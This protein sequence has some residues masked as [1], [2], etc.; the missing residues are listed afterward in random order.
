MA[1]PKR[2]IEPGPAG[3]RVAANLAAIRSN[4]GINQ[5]ELADRVTL[6]GRPM[7]GPV[8]SKTEKLDRRVDVDD[9][10][11]FAIALSTTPN[12]LLLAGQADGSD[13]DLAPNATVS[14]QEAWEWASGRIPLTLRRQPAPW[15]QAS[16]SDEQ[17]EEEARGFMRENAPYDHDLQVRFNLEIDELNKNPEVAAQARALVQ[18]A[19]QRGLSMWALHSA[20]EI[21]GFTEQNGQPG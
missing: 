1:K 18:L 2:A 15:Q 16:E 4:R 19:L 20:I 6:L 21:Y 13:I 3:E 17:A 11:T 9:L 12:R 5:A 14:T 10:V 7:S 8:V